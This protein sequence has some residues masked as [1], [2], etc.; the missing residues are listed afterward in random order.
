MKLTKEMRNAF[1]GFKA[2]KTK[3]PRTVN[4]CVQ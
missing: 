4:C 2:T 3:N 1:L